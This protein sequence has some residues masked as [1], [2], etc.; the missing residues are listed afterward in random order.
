MHTVVGSID[1]I[2]RPFSRVRV[3]TRGP[4]EE[5]PFDRFAECTYAIFGTRARLSPRPSQIYLHEYTISRKGFGT[6]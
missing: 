2:I 3:V 4:H 6:Q 5:D 1:V